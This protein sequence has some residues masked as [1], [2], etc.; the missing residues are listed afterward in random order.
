MRDI[1]VIFADAKDE[2]AIKNLL[3]EAGLPHEDIG[4]CSSPGNKKSL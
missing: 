3:L 4:L 2:E 1:T